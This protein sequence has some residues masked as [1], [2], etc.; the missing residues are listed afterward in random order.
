MGTRIVEDLMK[1]LVVALALSASV[2]ARR[3]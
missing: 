3:P 1:I 2:A